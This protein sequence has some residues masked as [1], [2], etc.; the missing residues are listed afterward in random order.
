MRT[1]EWNEETKGDICEAL[2]AHHDDLLSPTTVLR[3]QPEVFKNMV[4]ELAL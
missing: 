3:D 1:A 2:L 4:Q